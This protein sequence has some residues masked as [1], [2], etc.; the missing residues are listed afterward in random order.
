[1]RRLAGVVLTASIALVGGCGGGQ[2]QPAASSGSMEDVFVTGR[3]TL[4]GAAFD[5]R[6][7]GA[8]VL[9][10]GLVTP[11]QYSV[12]YVFHGRYDITVLGQSE[13]SGCGRP[14]NRIALWVSANDRILYSTNTL[15]W[16]SRRG[17]TTFA[18]TYS[19]RSPNGAVPPLA[20]FQG[21]L[22]KRGGQALP[23]G[24]RVEAFVGATRCGVA[25][26]RRTFDFTGY[27]LAVVGPE[28]IPG[29]TRGAVL[30][31]RIN[32]RPAL[33]TNMVNTPPGRQE[34]LDLKQA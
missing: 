12:Q 7:L 14:G 18:A 6:F 8:V 13:A 28:S 22:L 2:P 4:D 23:P 15:D 11:C 5:S 16:P 24:T 26:V 30:T 19:S 3:A 34:S 1:M 21:S 10:H 25:S 33:P 31:F 29:C 17:K 20:E 32:G 9:D 27:I